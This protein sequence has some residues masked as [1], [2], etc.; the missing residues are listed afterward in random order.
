ME[1]FQHFCVP[2][3]GT[4]CFHNICFVQH[5]L[6]MVTIE[7]VCADSHQRNDD[8]DKS[9]DDDDGSLSVMD[10]AEPVSVSQVCCG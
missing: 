6:N 10:V 9:D 7:T 1:G 4:L 2:R 3:S 5:L 8:D